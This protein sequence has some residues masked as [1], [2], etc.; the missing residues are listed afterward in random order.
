[1]FIAR[2]VDFLH[3]VRS[4]MFIDPYPIA[5][6]TIMTSRH[7]A[8]LKECELSGGS[9]AINMAPL[10]GCRGFLIERPTT[11]AQTLTT[12][13]HSTIGGYSK[14]IIQISASAAARV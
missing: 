3:S 5:P 6:K 8:L 1:M 13:A 9:A 4:A 7:I 2:A 14:L 12:P 11:R 10:E